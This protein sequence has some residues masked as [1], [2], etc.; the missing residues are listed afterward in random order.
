[1]PMYKKSLFVLLFIA[2]IATGIT[3]YR[4]NTQD[5]IA[6]NNTDITPQLITV[7]ISG[8]VNNPGVIELSSDAT[9]GD[10]IKQ[11]NGFTPLADKNKLNLAQKLSDGMHIIITAQNNQNMISNDSDKNS[12]LININTATKDQLDSLPGVGPSTAQK[13]ID[14]RQEHG[15]YQSIEDLKQVKGIGEA[16]FNKLKDKIT[17]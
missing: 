17:I 6:I 8:E 16:K 4:L 11:C 1:M 3:Y 5:N 2:I 9:L 7:Y 13:I 12:T 10:A 15:T 14:Y